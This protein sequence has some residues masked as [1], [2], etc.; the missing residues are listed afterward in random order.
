MER[1][2]MRTYLYASAPCIALVLGSDA[3]MIAARLHAN[4]RSELEPDVSVP[5]RSLFMSRLVI[6]DAAM[7]R[8]WPKLSSHDAAQRLF[9]K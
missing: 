6:A 3:C 1:M 4:V 2:R 9:I 8:P 5:A 7:S